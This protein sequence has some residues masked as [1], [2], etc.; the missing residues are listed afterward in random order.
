MVEAS[1][2]VVMVFV[3]SDTFLDGESGLNSLS[4][5]AKPGQ[6]REACVSRI[7]RGK[8]PSLD[9]EGAMSHR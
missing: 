3:S 2:S 1:E 9:D 8:F 7:G 6:G 4:K 5:T